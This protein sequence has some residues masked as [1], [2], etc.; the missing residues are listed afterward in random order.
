[1]EIG[2]RY[3][4]FYFA[5]FAAGYPFQIFNHKYPF[6]SSNEISDQYFLNSV[7][8]L[9]RLDFYNILFLNY[10]LN[11]DLNQIIKNCTK[12]IFKIL[13]FEFVL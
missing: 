12:V 4:N 6:I 2:K 8:T 5:K 3:F 13:I 11:F 7:T 1:M 10:F 9:K